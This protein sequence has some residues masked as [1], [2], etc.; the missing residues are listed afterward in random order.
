MKATATR[1]GRAFTLIE[2]LVVIAII[3]ILAA[4]LLPA[5]SGAKNKGKATQCINNLREIGVGLRLWAND[6]N[7]K[8]PWSVAA[9]DGGSGWLVDPMPDDWADNFR[10]A[11]NELVTPRILVCPAHTTKSAPPG[12]PLTKPGSGKKAAGAAAPIRT[13][14][15]ALD[16]YKHISY[17][18]GLDAQESKPQTILA[19]DSGVSSGF[20]S[21]DFIFTGTSGSSIDIAFDSTMH[22]A[23][24]SGYGHIVLSD[25]SVHHV[26]TTQLREY[27]ITA[28]TSGNGVSNACHISL[29]RGVQ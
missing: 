13:G 19:G 1:R 27:I 8:F 18:L 24:S 11:S 12:T 2:L 7:E 16:G 6:N 5:L 4:L 29:P 25:A 28:I 17:F 10:A 26:T 15:A 21:E 23:G 20:G 22:T 9:V 3:A 14:W